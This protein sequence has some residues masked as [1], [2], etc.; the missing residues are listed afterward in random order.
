MKLISTNIIVSLLATV[1]T[2]GGAESVVRMATSDWFRNNFHDNTWAVKTR[3]LFDGCRLTDFNTMQPHGFYQ[4]ASE[5]PGL[6]YELKPSTSGT[7]YKVPVRINSYGLRGPEIS[8]DKS[9]GTYR[10]AVLG[11]SA[12][13]GYGATEDVI[14]PSV[15]QE[16]LTQKLEQPV[17]VLNFG[18]AGYSTSQESA[19]LAS[20]V[21]KFD[22]DLIIVAQALNDIY[23]TGGVSVSPGPL[24]EFLGGHS[25]L[26]SCF[27]KGG[28][29]GVKSMSGS[30]K[31]RLSY[32]QIYKPQSEYWP[33]YDTELKNLKEIAGPTP[34]VMVLL[35][36]WDKLDTTYAYR[37]ARQELAAH[38]GK[39][40]LAIIDASPSDSI[41]YSLPALDYRAFAED[42]DHPNALGHAKLSEIIYNGLVTQH[43]LPN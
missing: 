31:P 19:Q 12:T 23:G 1:I 34:I 4:I 10:V 32:E 36:L 8:T 39:Y 6:L 13:F 25:S 29:L 3:I 24:L 43:L 20:K 30:V 40:E 9:P 2:L 18:V 26:F 15:L 33:E 7:L 14:F 21:K 5:P 17:E 22:P 41:I 11:D 38:A 37:E 27:N 28:S 42:L 35:P 16:K